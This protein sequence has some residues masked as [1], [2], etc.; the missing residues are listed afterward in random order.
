[1]VRDKGSR[2]GDDSKAGGKGAGTDSG[3]RTPTLS[4]SAP[5]TARPSRGFRGTFE[6]LNIFFSRL[7][8]RHLRSKAVD[9]LESSTGNLK[10][11]VGSQEAG[12]V[13]K[14]YPEAFL[15][16]NLSLEDARSLF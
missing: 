4:I 9:A 10:L 8:A 2:V 5:W 7:K 12:K 3:K 14:Y 1:M 6:T 13:E 16:T 11:W 15:V